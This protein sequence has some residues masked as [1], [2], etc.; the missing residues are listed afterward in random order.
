V[1]RWLN[2]IE[3]VKALTEEGILELVMED[4]AR[5]VV[6]RVRVREAR[7][8]YERH[9]RRLLKAQARR[10]TILGRML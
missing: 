5:D 8:D 10:D 9:K 1:N 7:K 3:E 4:R 6:T 2:H